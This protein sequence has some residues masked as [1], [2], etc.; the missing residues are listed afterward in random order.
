MC[1]SLGLALV[2]L[3]RRQLL[4]SPLLPLPLQ[5]PPPP[6]SLPLLFLVFNNEIVNFRKYNRKF[7]FWDPSGAPDAIQFWES[8]YKNIAFD[9]VIYVLDARNYWV[10]EK[11]VES[12]RDD[13]M[14]LHTL[15]CAPEL[16]R[17]KFILYL[18]W[19]TQL[20]L[21]DNEKNML[22]AIPDEL[23]L[24]NFP[25]RE[26]IVVD[27]FEKLEHALLT[28]ETDGEGDEAAAQ[29]IASP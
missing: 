7:E 5:T 28:V 13:R 23:E 14:E 24:Y 10:K 17:C 18:N 9:V 2:F 6:L 8:L 12:V 19:K 11:R 3:G 27:T 1:V 29:P 15:L 25:K 26:I 22:E 4:T 16:N 21:G 20:E